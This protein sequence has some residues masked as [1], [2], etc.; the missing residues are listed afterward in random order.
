MS[1]SKTFRS[2]CA[3][4]T[5]ALTAPLVLVAC[6]SDGDP[7]FSSS[8]LSAGACR[9]ADDELLAV[10]RSQQELTAGDIEPA[11][12]ASDYKE[13][14]DRLLEAREGAPAEVGDA[15]RS[16]VTAMGYF[17][18]GV[19]AGTVDDEQV[20]QLQAALDEALTACGVDL[21]D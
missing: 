9:E 6:S 4:L 2:R 21:Q 8:D 17:R 5:L 3:V 7:R 10:E 19:D 16:L 13:L 15:L 20:D 12:A 1:P 11:A 14:Q 18:V